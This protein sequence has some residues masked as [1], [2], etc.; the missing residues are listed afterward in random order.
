M[1][2][3]TKKVIL[4]GECRQNVRVLQIGGRRV[5]RGFDPDP[6]GNAPGETFRE[7]NWRTRQFSE[8]AKRHSRPLGTPKA[9]FAGV[10]DLGLSV[11]VI[12]DE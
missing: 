8:V 12:G 11:C 9:L 1:S 10:F 7:K 5:R 6:V 3:G 4:S 2:S